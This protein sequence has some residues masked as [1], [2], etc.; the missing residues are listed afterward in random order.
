MGSDPG[1][2]GLGRKGRV[3]FGGNERMEAVTI[4]E[5]KGKFDTLAF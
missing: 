1:R 4:G 5:G 2:D 3:D